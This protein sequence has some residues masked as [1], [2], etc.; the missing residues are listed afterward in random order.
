MVKY[1]CNFDTITFKLKYL[2]CVM[3]YVTKHGPVYSK[4]FV[5]VREA[6]H[7]VE[8]CTLGY[9]DRMDSGVTASRDGAGPDAQ[10]LVNKHVSNL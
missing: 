8:C 4:Q 3:K 5:V 7:K 2:W 1:I 9:L 6:A 10:K